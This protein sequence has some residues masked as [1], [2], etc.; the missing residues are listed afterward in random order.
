MGRPLQLRTT[1][2]SAF[3]LYPCPNQNWTG[4]I[5]S[6]RASSNEKDASRLGSVSAM[7]ALQKE[8]RS[9][10]SRAENQGKQ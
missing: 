8:E 10:V 5:W 3:W 2:H 7:R 1:P 6:A 4:S 9:E